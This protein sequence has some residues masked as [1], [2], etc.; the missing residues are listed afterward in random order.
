MKL[1][2]SLQDWDAVY[3]YLR[4]HI[5]R[6]GVQKLGRK[7]AARTL[8]CSADWCSSCQGCVLCG[9]AAVEF[10]THIC[11]YTKPMV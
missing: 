6:P 1:H 5:S 2:A 8:V 7:P 4:V 3:L 9:L 10:C 11:K